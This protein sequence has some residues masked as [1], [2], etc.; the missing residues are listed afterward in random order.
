MCSR[1]L[2]HFRD[3]LFSPLSGHISVVM[4]FSMTPYSYW[5]HLCYILSFTQYLL[6]CSLSDKDLS[7]FTD[8]YTYLHFV[9]IFYPP[10]SKVFLAVCTI[11]PQPVRNP[12]VVARLPFLHGLLLSRC[13]GSRCIRGIRP[14]QQLV[15]WR[16]FQNVVAFQGQ[17]LLRGNVRKNCENSHVAIPVHIYNLLWPSRRIVS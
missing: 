5:T 6:G 17:I 3:L 15:H 7:K 12:W 1:F 10:Q 14:T 13:P 11:F 4:Y 9:A 8:L 16:G 2:L